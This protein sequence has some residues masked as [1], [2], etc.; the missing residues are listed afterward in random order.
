MCKITGL[1]VPNGPTTHYVPLERSQHPLVKVDPN[2]IKSYNPEQ[3]PLRTHSEML[4]QGQEVENAPSTAAANR[5]AKQY[6]V[7]GVPLLSHLDSLSFPGSFPYDFMHLIWENLIKNLVLLW[8]GEFK[9]LDEGSGEYVLGKAVWEAVA[10]LGASAGDTIPSAYGSRIPNL[11][12]DRPNVSAEMWGFWTQ[13]LGPVLLHR[14]FRKERYY[15][16]FLELVRL[17]NICLKFENT[18]AEIDEVRLGFVDWVQKYEKFYYQY[19]PDRLPTCP[20][21]IHALLHI[22]DSIK[23][24]GPVWAYWAFPM[25]RFCGTLTPAIRSRRHPW[26]S[27]D[28]HILEVAQLTQVKMVY[29]VVRDLDLDYD[30][31]DES[32]STQDGFSDPACCVLSFPLISKLIIVQ[33]PSCI[34]LPPRAPLRPTETQV[35]AIAGAIVTRTGCTITQAN[36]ALRHAL[37][38]EYGRVK[39]IDS[40]AGDTMRSSNL[41]IRP[42]DSRDNTYI[43]YYAII[44]LNARN[45]KAPFKYAKE[46]FYGQLNHIYRITFPTALPTLNI[47]AATTMI[48]A[49]IRT[50]NVEPVKNKIDKTLSCLNIRMYSGHR[51]LDIIDMKNIVGLVGRIPLTSNRWAIIDR[52]A[53]LELAEWE[54]DINADQSNR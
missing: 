14:R 39:R 25:E 12:K 13:Y 5:L 20:L 46:V 30:S 7:K 6:G 4:Q 52:N 37:I 27:L 48:F 21:T 35:R 17:L 29:N 10:S 38:E 31:D 50:C 3:L 9:G 47:S 32:D 28:R 19:K 44:D 53:V 54:G 18:R 15:R 16:H 24:C 49:A 41:G 11:S 43:S 1:R 8:T 2:A 42:E 40:E 33:D 36:I 22:A 34:L 45:K 26:A 23:F 51:E